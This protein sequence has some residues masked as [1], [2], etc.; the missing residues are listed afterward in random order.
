MRGMTEPVV[1]AP[2]LRRVLILLEML[3]RPNICS[4]NWVCRQ[5]DHEVQGTSVIKPLV[6]VERDVPSDAAV[7]RPVLTSDRGLAFAQALMPFYSSIDAYHMTTCTIDE[8]CAGWSPWAATSIIIGGVDN[9]CWP[10]IQY[11]AVKNPDGKHKAAQAGAVVQGARSDVHGL[12][13]TAALRQGFNVR[14][15]SSTG[16]LRRIP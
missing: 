15:W 8:A 1:T 11:D 14:G 6:G 10:N 4:K 12:W 7:I 16:S 13:H 3:G 9:F 5:Y 2:A